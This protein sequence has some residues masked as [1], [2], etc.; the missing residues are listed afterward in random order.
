M[1]EIELHHSLVSSRLENVGHALGQASL[2]A[3]PLSDGNQLAFTTSWDENENILQKLL[4]AYQAAVRKNLADT[5]A[6][7]DSLKRQDEVIR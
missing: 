1:F 4:S 6:N 3:L 2:P 5:Q 7:V